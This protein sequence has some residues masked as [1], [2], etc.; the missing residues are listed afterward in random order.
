MTV[1]SPA[2]A[3]FQLRRRLRARRRQ[4]SDIEQQRAAQRLACLG[5]RLPLFRRSRRLAFYWAGDGEISL[6]PLLKVAWRAGKD[7]CLPVIQRDGSMVFRRYERGDPMGKNRLGIAEPQPGS[8]ICPVEQLDLIITPMLA[9]DRRG[10]RLGRGG[11]HYDRVLASCHLSGFRAR[12]IGA[13]HSLQ[14]CAEVPAEPWDQRVQG[15]LTERGFLLCRR[16]AD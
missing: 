6:L 11:G 4:L 10:G 12:L 8:G 14:E 3:K 16:G 9:F 13:A 7:V 1:S 5:I 2:H 15:V